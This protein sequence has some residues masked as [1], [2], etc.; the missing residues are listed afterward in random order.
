[1]NVYIV[2]NTVILWLKWGK[3]FCTIE[4]ISEP[5]YWVFSMC[6][7]QNLFPT[8]EIQCIHLLIPY[9][10]LGT[11]LVLL[12]VSCYLLDI[13]L[14]CLKIDITISIFQTVRFWLRIQV[15][16]P[17]NCLVVSA[18]AFIQTQVLPLLNILADSKSSSFE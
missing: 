9:F 1:M 13:L 15:S 18:R 4:N 7:F 10:F 6:G 3:T 5:F 11:V 17:I 12:Q 2:S 16:C 8:V 14:I